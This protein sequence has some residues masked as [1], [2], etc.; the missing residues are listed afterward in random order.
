ML[1]QAKGNGGRLEIHDVL[2]PAAENMTTAE[3][4]ILA[5]RDHPSLQ[6]CFQHPAM[7]DAQRDDTLVPPICFV[8]TG[9]G[10]AFIDLWGTPADLVPADV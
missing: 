3:Q 9:A 7:M 2:G 4:V 10:E 6:W 1:L 8:L 5:V